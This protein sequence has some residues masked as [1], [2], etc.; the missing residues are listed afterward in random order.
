MNTTKKT[1]FGSYGV[2]CN[3]VKHCFRNDAFNFLSAINSVD[4]LQY[5]ATKEADN[6]CEVCGEEIDNNFNYFG[7]WCCSNCVEVCPGCKVPEEECFGIFPNCINEY[8]PDDLEANIQ[9]KFETKN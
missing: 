7:T 1:I 4:L 3:I 6:P 2:L 8:Q 9:Y 5:M